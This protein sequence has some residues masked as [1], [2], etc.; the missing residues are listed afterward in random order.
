MAYEHKRGRCRRE[1]KRREAWPSDRVQA[2]AYAVLLEENL[3]Q[4]VP[5][6]RIRYRGLLAAAMLACSSAGSS[7]SSTCPGSTF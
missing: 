6:A 1:E 4:P 2:V 7:V 5:Q 3:G